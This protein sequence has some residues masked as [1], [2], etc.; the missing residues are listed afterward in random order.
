M[1]QNKSVGILL[2]GISDTLPKKA[3]TEEKSSS[4]VKSVVKTDTDMQTSDREQLSLNDLVK[5]NCE[6]QISKT[7]LC[8]DNTSA[9]G[10][11]PSSSEKQRDISHTATE[12]RPLSVK[13]ESSDRLSKFSKYFKR[14]NN[15]VRKEEEDFVKIVSEDNTLTDSQVDRELSKLSLAAYAKSV[16]FPFDSSQESSVHHNLCDIKRKVKGAVR[17]SDDDQS[18]KTPCDA[19]CLDNE[20]IIISDSSDEEVG[21]ADKEET[22]KMNEN[23]CPEKQP[24]TSSSIS[25]SNIKL[26]SKTLPSSPSSLEDCESQCF[27]FETEGDVFSVWQDTQA[28]SMEPTQEYKQ[29]HVS[30]SVDSSNSD[31]L[32]NDYINEW[33]YDMDYISDDAMDEKA[34]LTENQTENISHQKEVDNTEVVTNSTLQEFSSKGNA[35]DQLENSYSGGGR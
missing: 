11:V 1:Q 18:T 12:I 19:D 23:V 30:T 5:Y 28:Y 4:L 16:N 9:N 10:H 14:E 15:S 3:S 31:S 13:C 26:E 32:L 20:V 22:K 33:G 7:T 25:D 29:D 34:N 35:E 2:S 6:G 27:E 17:S 24:S 8:T 21:V